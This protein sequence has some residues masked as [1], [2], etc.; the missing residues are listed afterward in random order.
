MGVQDAKN[1]VAKFGIVKIHCTHVSMALIINEQKYPGC[2]EIVRY[3]VPKDSNC[4]F[5]SREKR[6]DLV[7]VST[8]STAVV[9]TTV[10]TTAIVSTISTIITT[11]IVAA[12]I[13]TAIVAA[14]T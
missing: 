1:L 14:T 4:A 13:T 6:R 10:I 3:Y 9:S 2:E 8:I 12:T 11:A 7:I 5:P